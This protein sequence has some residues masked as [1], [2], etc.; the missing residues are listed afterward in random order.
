VPVFRARTPRLPRS[1]FGPTRPRGVSRPPSD[2][3]R[4]E[5]SYAR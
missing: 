2:P 4:D 5:P 3:R 1:E